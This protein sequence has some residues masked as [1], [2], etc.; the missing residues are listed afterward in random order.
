[1]TLSFETKEKAG[2]LEALSFSEGGGSE[3]SKTLFIM[4]NDKLLFGPTSGSPHH[5]L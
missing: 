3:R 2:N 1:M 5:L 4:P